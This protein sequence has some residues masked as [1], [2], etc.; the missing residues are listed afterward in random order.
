MRAPALV[1][2]GLVAYGVVLVATM[3]ARFVAAQIESREPG[4]LRV[5][6]AHGTVWHGAA[7]VEV[8]LGP[9]W[10][11]I[12]SLAWRLV[13]REL[14]SGRLAFAVD[15]QAADA[16][17]KGVIARSAAGWHARGEASAP[18]SFAAAVMPLAG[19]WRPE[20]RIDVRTE[21]VAWDSREVRGDVVAEWRDAA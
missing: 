10:L 5:H 20:G 12:E 15:A 19:T 4:V 8:A 7:R 21:G 11:P 9:A 1:A 2:I 6:E 17:G 13:P 14:L 3:P 18:A 16:A